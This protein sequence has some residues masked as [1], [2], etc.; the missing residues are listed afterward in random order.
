MTRGK[1]DEELGQSE[2][3]MP[4]VDAYGAGMMPVLF[5]WQSPTEQQM[6]ARHLVQLGKYGDDS[7][8]ITSYMVF[9][10]RRNPGDP[11]TAS[12]NRDRRG[13]K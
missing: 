2:S 1:R 11:N 5:M 3:T 10:E 9:P 8:A 7:Q 6:R 13:D 4:S 12:D